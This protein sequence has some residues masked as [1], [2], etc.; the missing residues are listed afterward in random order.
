MFMIG[1]GSRAMAKWTGKGW[2]FGF[3]PYPEYIETSA[4]GATVVENSGTEISAGCSG[5]SRVCSG[6]VRA[7]VW[8]QRQHVNRSP[9]SGTLGCNLILPYRG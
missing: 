9:A 6:E 7:W 3:G 2:H 5:A 1:P 8:L 4:L